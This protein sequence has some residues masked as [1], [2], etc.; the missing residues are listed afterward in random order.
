MAN[1]PL[2]GTRVADFS[3]GVAGPIAAM[4]LADLG[5][6]VIKVEPKRGDWVRSVGRKVENGMS[7][8][9]VSM[10]RNKKGICVDMKDAEGL[11]AVTRLA[12]KS[13][14]VV[15]SFRPGVMERFGLAYEQ[16]RGE[17]PGLVYASVTGYGRS[18][19]YV[20]LPGADS[21]IQAMGGIM[22][23]NGVA[24]GEPLRFGMFMVDMIAGMT[25]YQGILAAL[26][27]K[28]Q[29]GEGQNVNVSLL[30]AILAFQAPLL[31]EYLM[32]GLLPER[33]GNVNSFVAPSGV[34]KTK[35]SYMMF[36]VLDHLWAN[37]CQA[38]GMEELRHDARFADNAGR[39]AHR[40]A[41]LPRVR[42]KL[43]EKTTA[44]WL[45][46]LRE[47]DI[48]CAPINDYEKLVNDPQVLANGVLGTL[49]HPALG[50]LPNVRNP[51]QFGALELTYTPPPVL[52]EHS[53][54]VLQDELGY[55]TAEVDALVAAD[56]IRDAATPAATGVE[57][58]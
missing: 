47:H 7:P 39:L 18:G 3:Q 12:R 14:I 17:Q 25:A 33:N 16:L 28:A 36:T 22:S 55:S 50:T 52:G 38:L 6:T 53:R 58:A 57:V 20:D 23:I 45:A 26:L 4:L 35:D 29:S 44:E 11:Q 46:L 15:E 49:R 10:N 56:V 40:E 54:A 30:D 34:F 1:L 24:G 8:T 48:L 31:T 41:L 5:A 9:Y 21:V 43:A 37:C 2:Q 51:V 27:G 42:D 19:P 32:H 13:D